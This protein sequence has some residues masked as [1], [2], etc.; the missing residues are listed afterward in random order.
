MVTLSETIE[1]E[2]RK[3]SQRVSVFI[4]VPGTNAMRFW[5]G[6]GD[7]ESAAD[8]ILDP[9]EI[10]SGRGELVSM[11]QIGMLI[12]GIAER[13][14]F[15][16]SG[17]DAG[18]RAYVNDPLKDI[19]GR[20]IHMGLRWFGDNLSPLAAT[21]WMWT[22]T[23]DTVSSG[24][25]G[26]VAS[27]TLSCVT[28]RGRRMASGARYWTNTNHKTRHPTDAFCRRVALYSTTYLVRWP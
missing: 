1:A 2:V 16:L 13:V 9:S 27:V 22:G 19:R 20:K 7:I 11:P 12:N 26:N 6:I 23:I 25:S 17:A 28:S 18:L 15:K 10:Y 3:E 14:S 8:D 4:Y 24:W 21:A 5:T